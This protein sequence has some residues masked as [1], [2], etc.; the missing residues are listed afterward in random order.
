MLRHNNIE[1]GRYFMEIIKTE[2]RT[3]KSL[4]IFSITFFGGF[5]LIGAVP[6][7]LLEEVI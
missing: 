1:K 4:M 6:S 5:G 3:Y 7:L 2:R